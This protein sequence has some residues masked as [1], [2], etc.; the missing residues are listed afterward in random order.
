MKR[1]SILLIAAFSAPVVAQE[2]DNPPTAPAPT[3]RVILRID[4]E[5]GEVVFKQV[6]RVPVQIAVPVRET[7]MQDGMVVEVTRNVTR[8]VM[9]NRETEQV[10][11]LKGNQ[12]LDGA[13]Q[14][15][16]AE[17]LWKRLKAGDPVI[18]VAG[19]E[20]DPVWRKLLKPDAVILLADPKGSA[21][22]GAAPAKDGLSDEE[23]QL[24][25]L[26]NTERKKAD[27]G[28][29]KVNSKLMKAARDHSANM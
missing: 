19:G 29:L 23:R 7:I 24:V 6:E 8:T 17:Q 22:L 16:E 4:A 14:P 26:V 12:A 11:R 25:E 2:K 18:V 5:K 21:P 9:K 10:W 3:F 15:I 13:G 27:L 28:P 20:L 1:T